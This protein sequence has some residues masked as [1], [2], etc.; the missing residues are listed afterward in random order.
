[1]AARRSLA[2]GRDAAAAGVAPRARRH[3]RRPRRPERD[4]DLPLQRHGR[5]RPRPCLRR[6]LRLR[7]RRD[8]RRSR[9]DVRRTRRPRGSG[10][11]GDDRDL[12]ARVPQRQRD[13]TRRL[14]HRHRRVDGTAA[15][16]VRHRRIDRRADQPSCVGVVRRRRPAC[17]PRRHLPQRRRA[18]LGGRIVAT[19]ETTQ[20]SFACMLGG[21][22]RTTL[23]V[24]TAGTSV[25]AEAA[26]HPTGRL[27]TVRVDAAGAGLP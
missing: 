6:E 5:R 21:D 26:K 1:V 25:A 11:H 3:H 18:H 22:D 12:A 24:L 27:E 4:R 9:R 13:H 14:D 10:R 23:F 7:P 17:H 8:A 2:H 16:C 15:Q 19:V 20:P